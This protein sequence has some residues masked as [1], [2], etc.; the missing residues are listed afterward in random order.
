[1]R[2]IGSLV[3]AASLIVGLTACGGGNNAT[4]GTKPTDTA[5]GS[6]EQAAATK[7]KESVKAKLF[8]D[9][10]AWTDYLKEI[11]PITL[12]NDQTELTGVPY[13][14]PTSFQT[15]VRIGFTTN[16]GADVFKWWNGFQMK[17]LVD[18]GFLADMTQQWEDMVK[19]GV[20]PSMAS[21]LTFD[22]KT[23]GIPAG[24]HYWVMYYNKKV[25]N[26]NG[27]KPPKTW[28]EFLTVSDAL[29]AKGIT[30]IGTT[31]T[32]VWNGFIW[33]EEMMIHSN[34]DLYN[35]LVIGQ[36]KYTDPGVVEVMKTWKSLYDK[37]YFAKPMDWNKEIPS[38]MAK[39]QFAMYMMG[40]WYSDYFKNAGMKP[41]E[42]FGTFVLPAIK[43]E[44]GNTVISEVT[45]FLVSQNSKNKDNAIKALVNL[46]KK[47]ANE[48]VLSL[49][50]GVPIRKD[51]ESKDP[52]IKDLVGTINAGGYKSITRFWEATP[53]ELSEY[54]SSEFVRFML[55][56]DQYMTVLNNIQKKADKYWADHK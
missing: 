28:D 56:P 11:N 12:K 24:V 8:Y 51:L 6:N 17:E 15:A 20:D 10:A 31:T 29:K 14:E 40:T 26:D 39:G 54:A 5:K 41:G 9:N 53:S 45:P 48:K 42:D 16:D 27:L 44:A 25:F 18:A 30:P 7:A 13:N 1:M 43:S 49:Y 52:I 2:K 33:F 35:K 22:G 21:T 19:D 3:V 55:N 36:A 50:G 37:G 46:T 47:E 38:A 23:Y 34:P 32:D 4:S